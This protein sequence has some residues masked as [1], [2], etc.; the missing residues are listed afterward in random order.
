MVFHLFG[1]AG[2]FVFAYRCEGSFSILTTEI[3]GD[4]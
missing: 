2:L 1:I 3:C 4:T